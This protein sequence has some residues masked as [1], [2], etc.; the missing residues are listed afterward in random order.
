VATLRPAGFDIRANAEGLI[1][2][3]QAVSA[4]SNGA[5]RV[6]SVDIRPAKAQ[7]AEPGTP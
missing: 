4:G 5:Y 3:R 6:V 7:A 2:D 1:S